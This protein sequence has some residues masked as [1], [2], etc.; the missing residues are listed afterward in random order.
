MM[1]VSAQT[2]LQVTV[3]GD[4]MEAII[5][6]P[7][8]LECGVMAPEEILE[9]LHEAGVC[10]GIKDDVVRRIARDGLNSHGVIVACGMQPREGVPGH[11]EL[12]VL[13]PDHQSK[14]RTVLSVRKGDILA[15]LHP[16]TEGTPGVT[17]TGEAL[18]CSPGEPAHL[19]SGLNTVFGPDGTT[20]VATEDGLP[21]QM[22]DGSVEVHT[23][24]EIPHNV[25]YSVGNVDFPGSLLIRGDVLGEF[26]IRAGGSVEIL[27][28]V[29][30]ALIESG[31]DVTIHQGF[32]G[33]G[34][35]RITAAGTVR[36]RH[37]TNQTIKA[38]KD[39]LVETEAV[40]ATIEA[41][42]R[43]IAPRAV[44]AGGRLEAMLEADLYHLGNS[45]SSAVKVR[46]GRRRK[47]IDRLALVE[48][49][50][51]QAERQTTE[52]KDAVY[53][54][55]KMKVDTGRLTTDKEQI[56][57]KLQAAQRI[58]PGRLQ[59]L[60]AERELLH[61]ELQKKCD[62]RVIVRG[63]V[64]KDSMIEVNGAGKFVESALEA[65]VFAEWNGVLESR[66]M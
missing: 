62:A 18:P 22:P 25:D 45:E 46:V 51:K 31:G 10:T 39:V 7:A 20:V 5:Q 17:V 42:G 33:V 55:V 3:S 6:S 38:G 16:P 56:L 32:V 52:L 13:P 2:V 63:T 35:G 27:G 54:L 26:N 57:A 66:S 36:V 60:L 30:D 53:R 59:E 24:V 65:V 43:V 12:I 49:D 21:V 11:I 19:K 15:V 48:K 34:K 47:I 4:G 41:G 64:Q 23:T 61:G 14:M 9:V 8:P 1:G 58:L 28:D 29:Q 37:V 40:N 44:I 50:V